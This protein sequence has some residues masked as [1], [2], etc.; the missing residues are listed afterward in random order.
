MKIK[1]LILSLPLAVIGIVSAGCASHPYNTV[2]KIDL[3]RFMGTWYV[4]GGRFTPLEKGVHNGVET[5]SLNPDENNIKIGFTFN[6]DSLTGKV[7]SIPQKGWV[8][9]KA[10]KAHWKVQPWWPFQFN[11]L[12]VAI[13]DDYSWTAIGVPDQQYLWIMARDWK[14]PEPIMAAAIKKLNDIGY[15]ATIDTKVP[16]QH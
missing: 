13:A 3:P 12:V 14:N 16:H 9:N 5:Y 10:T 15:N 8:F 7:K 1:R 4:L 11:Y 2:E 6:K